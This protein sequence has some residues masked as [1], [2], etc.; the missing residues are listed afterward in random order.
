VKSNI[1]LSR[2][3]DVLDIYREPQTDSMQ[4]SVDSRDCREAEI[5]CLC[6]VLVLRVPVFGVGVEIELRLDWPGSKES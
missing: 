1:L 2:S 6:S 5:V 4:C 3:K